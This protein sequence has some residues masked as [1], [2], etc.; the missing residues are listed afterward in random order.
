MKNI[1]CLFVCLFVYNL[2]SQEKKETVF[3]LFDSNNKK[4]CSTG[5]STKYGEIVNKYRKEERKNRTIFY[6]CEEAFVLD[7]R[8]KIDTCN[9]K[10]LR[11]IKLET[12]QTIES[13]RGVSKYAFKNSIFEKIYLIEKQ[14]N[15]IIKYPVIW[16]TDLIQK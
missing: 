9:I 12:L 10:Y 7:K 13:K 11:K 14:N 1:I 5:E 15:K 8:D 3:L 2:H 6:I 4:T 16:N